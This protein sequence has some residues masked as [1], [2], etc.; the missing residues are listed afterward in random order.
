MATNPR[1][2]PQP[3]GNSYF[4]LLASAIILSAHIRQSFS[5]I[6]LFLTAILP[7]VIWFAPLSKSNQ[8]GIRFQSPTKINFQ[9]GLVRNLFNIL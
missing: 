5:K 1:Q 2:I 9:F 8:I 4:S 3:S 6:A 7:P